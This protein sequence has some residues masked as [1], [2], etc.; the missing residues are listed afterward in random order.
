MEHAPTNVL[1]AVAGVPIGDVF[2]FHGLC[3]DCTNV[4]S[5]C[6]STS[7]PTLTFGKQ[8]PLG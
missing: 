7:C 3:F 1:K 6:N 5:C 4:P 8:L 2:F